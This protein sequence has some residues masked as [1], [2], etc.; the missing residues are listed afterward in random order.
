MMRFIHFKAPFGAFRPFKN[1]EFATTAEFITYSAAYGLL[2]GLAGREREQKYE[3]EGARIALG[4]N[5]LPRVGRTFQQLIQGKRELTHTGGE[6][7]LRPFWRELVC[8]LEGWIG[9]DHTL[10]ERLVE[11]GVEEAATLDYWGVPFMG[12]NNLFVE[13]IE[14]NERAQPCR[15]FC[16]FTGR[17]LPLGERLYYLSV[18]TDYQQNSRSASQ[19]FALSPTRDSLKADDDCWIT[20]EAM[21]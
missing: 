20:I 13:K 4:C 6:F 7:N 16:P 11:K 19:L 8:D 21:R 17:R 15:W 14:V 12:D 10:L 2:L 5:R 3:F 9:L 18:W 1:V